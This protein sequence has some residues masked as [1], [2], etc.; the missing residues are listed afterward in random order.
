[1]ENT[2]T[3]PQAQAKKGFFA[4]YSSDNFLK[5]WPL[6]TVFIGGLIGGLLGGIA[7]VINHFVLKSGMARRSKIFL[8]YATGSVA[9]TASLFISVA[10]RLAL[11]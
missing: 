10:V 9:I 5:F 6:M 3:T 11:G 8:C 4:I 7:V 1:M 2:E